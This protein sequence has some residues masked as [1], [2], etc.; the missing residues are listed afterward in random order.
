MRMTIYILAVLTLLAVF[1]A[2]Q[3]DPISRLEKRIDGLA[4]AASDAKAEMLKETAEL[5]EK[6]GELT[7]TL[8]TMNKILYGIFSA[9]CINLLIYGYKTFWRKSIIILAILAGL[10]LYPPPAG[11][12]QCQG[13]WGQCPG[14]GCFTSS[15]CGYPCFC[16]EYYVCQYPYPSEK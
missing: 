9:I 2:A 16:N 6:I 12:A 3:E 14:G 13:Q 15:D 4:G 11:V 10:V 5:R 1:S 8:G 7:G